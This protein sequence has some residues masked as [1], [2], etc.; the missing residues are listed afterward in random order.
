MTNKQ[1]GDPNADRAAE[2]EHAP[3]VA[4]SIQ[5]SGIHPSTSR[6]ITV[7]AVTFT[8]DG[9]EVDHF[10]AVVNPGDNPGPFHLHGLS[11]EEIAQGKKF[12]HILKP[13]GKLID[14]RTLI[15]HN[16][17][18]TWG[19]LVS[20]SRR[21]MSTAARANRARHRNRNHRRQRVG[22]I[23]RPRLIVDTLAT[24]RRQGVA[25]EDIRIR[26]VAHALGLDSPSPVAS[27]ERAAR[28]ESQV[29]REETLLIARMH[30]VEKACGV[31]SSYTPEQLRADKFGLQ[32]SDIRVDAMEVPREY[33][34]P[35]VYSPDSGF[36]QGMEVVIAPEI[37]EDPDVIIEATLR[38]G[39]AYNEKLTRKSSV[40]VCNKKED[41]V[42]K[43]MHG[44]RKE[45][46]LITDEEFLRAVV[47]VKP[48][49]AR[50]DD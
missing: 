45:I 25:F 32:R 15:L 36:V 34:N 21:A 3:Y 26:A 39:L 44:H 23:P 17:P 33:E 28:P 9:E 11:R 12:S 27:L 30:F 38:T 31:I 19:F 29:S 13:L 35:G 16:T 2:I 37:T 5:T 1:V 4:L 49:K 7:D 8:E 22:H 41:L 14:G 47:D 24:A 48:G 6:L 18:Y 46:P 42:G 20:E 43:A 50:E 40:V 10:H